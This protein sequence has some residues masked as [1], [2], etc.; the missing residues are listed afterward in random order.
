MR[1]W[2]ELSL[3][4]QACMDQAWEAYCD[5]CFPIGAVIVNKDRNILS[6]GRNRIY[7]KQ[8]GGRHLRGAE[9]AHAE[10][11]ALSHIDFDAIDP[12]SF[13][14]YTTTEP[15]PMCMGTFYMSGIRTLH[16]GSR[17]PYSGST[18]LL[19]TTWYL[20]LKPI[21]VFPPENRLLELIIMA[22]FIEQDFQNHNG[23]LPPNTETLY[24]RWLDAVP[25][26]VPFGRTLYESRTL[27]GARLD[28]IN[29]ANMLDL[30]VER[31]Q[32]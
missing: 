18:N 20:S 21:K 2:D 6:H 4:W 29:T 22:M 3:P 13:A 15:C 19:G 31:A 26:C 1:F 8:K 12:H 27:L 5:D 10:V 23:E 17:E 16:Y 24:Q 30:V 28:R 14:L 7:E 25:E 32:S 11:E 9:L